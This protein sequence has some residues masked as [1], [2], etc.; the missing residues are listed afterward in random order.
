MDEPLLSGARRILI[1]K[2]TSLG[3]IVQS[4]C[5]LTAIRNAFPEAHIS[6]LVADI[7]A[8]ILVGHPSIDEIVI[9]PRSLMKR[10]I[11]GLV[12]GM[13]SMRRSLSSGGFDAA[14]DFQGLFRSGLCTRFTN[15]PIRVGFQDARE[16]ATLF[17]NHRV[18]ADRRSEHA[19]VRY[20]AMA[21]Y[22]GA[23][24]DM[25]N[26]EFGLHPSEEMVSKARELLRGST[27]ALV[28]GA[29]WETKKWPLDNFKAVARA[30]KAR[31][32]KLAVLGS[33]AERELGEA[34][35]DELGDRDCINLAGR[36]TLR[37][38]A[39]CLYCCKVVLSN[40]SGP[41]HISAALGRPTVSLFGPTSPELAGP[42][43]WQDFVARA[44]VNCSGCHQRKC[45]K[46]P[47]PC[48]NS[49]HPDRV[50]DLIDRAL[51]L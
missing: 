10:G 50:L 20:M 38:L 34:I 37:E 7:F 47:L 9:F 3:D 36:T 33:Q 23:G 28:P 22:C 25:S 39:A 4:L 30:L 35:C 32:V 48:M 11:A 31:G 44:E 2:P 12:K 6:F 16:G 18:R 5:A 49:I 24:S 13:F 29:R 43:G 51:S 46:M 40:D 19:I 45:D 27:I 1:I 26:L 14:L 42:W 15:A 21:E 17:Y 41:M 8:D